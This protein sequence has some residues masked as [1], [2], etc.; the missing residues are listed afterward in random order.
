MGSWVLERRF[1]LQNLPCRV[2][3][4]NGLQ[5]LEI[6][7][8]TQEELSK[9]LF[10]ACSDPVA[11]L[12]FHVSIGIFE[13]LL[14]KIS[15]TL[16]RALKNQPRHFRTAICLSAAQEINQNPKAFSLFPQASTLET[17][18]ALL[19]LSSR[20]AE[21][22]SAVEHRSI[23]LSGKLEWKGMREK[24]VSFAANHLQRE[25]GAAPT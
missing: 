15:C 18:S 14:L 5:C 13:S 25:L 22:P 1:Y 16:L 2:L 4:A 23:S 6:S 21:M 3:S 9:G 20:T 17:P 24:W 7:I 8:P 10:F 11:M 19:Q 12:T